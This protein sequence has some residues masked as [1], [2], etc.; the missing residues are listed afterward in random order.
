MIC[1]IV[2]RTD[3]SNV[4]MVQTTYNIKNDIATTHCLFIENYFPLISEKRCRHSIAV[5]QSAL[6]RQ[7]APKIFLKQ[8]FHATSILCLSEG[9]ILPISQPYNNTGKQ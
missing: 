4:I 2:T 6:S 9:D 7:Q 1:H 8:L 3:F 5:K